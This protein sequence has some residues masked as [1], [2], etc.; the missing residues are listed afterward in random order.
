MASKKSRCNQIEEEELCQE[1]QQPCWKEG[2]ASKGIIVVPKR[3]RKNF[4]E[5]NVNFVKQH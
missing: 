2:V 3:K 1:E 5:R 4:V